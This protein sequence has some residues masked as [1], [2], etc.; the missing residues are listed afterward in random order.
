MDEAAVEW[1]LDSE[2]PAVRLAV[3]RDLLDEP[4]EEDA[5]RILTG[6]TVTALLSGQQPNGGFGGVGGPYA[7]WTGAHWRLVSLVDLGVPAAE[8]RIA[9]ATEHELAWIARQ[10][11]YRDKPAEIGGL[12]L[13]CGSV[14]GNALAVSS[15]LGLAAD[16]RARKVAET[17]ISAQWPD[18]GWNCD[19][20]A[21]GRRSSFHETL[22]TA[23]ALHEYAAATGDQAASAAAERA[24]ELFLEHR[25]LYSL[26]TGV[27]RRG[28]AHRRPAGEVINP[29]WLELRY[30]SYWHYD[31][32]RVLIILSRMGKLGDPRAGD[33]LDELER[34]RLP[35]GRWA[36]DGRWWN[37]AGSATTPEVIDWGQPGQPNLMITLNALQ[38][39]HAAGRVSFG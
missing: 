10:G 6:P 18:G 32:L 31:I 5:E 11:P 24:V 34:R 16:P 28:R 7:K 15:R 8:P 27:R 13:L 30:P 36:A 37:P 9:A 22:S 3:R 20:K 1:L 17:L 2:E 23:W 39:L 14:G 26:G 38:V 4:A 33:A 12:A 25:L 29:R 19:S 35:D 21:L